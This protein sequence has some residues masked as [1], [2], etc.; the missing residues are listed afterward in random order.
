MEIKGNEIIKKYYKIPMYIWIGYIVSIIVMAVAIY[1]MENIKKS[2]IPEPI[3]FT[4][5]GAIGME[6]NQ[7]AYLEVQGITDEIA[8]YGDA[9]N[10]TDEKND[11]YCIAFNNGYWY[12]VDLNFETIEQLKDIK[13]YTYSTDENATIP[14]SV[15]IYGMT[16]SVSDELKQMLIDYYNQSVEEEYKI[17]IDDFERYFG[18][19][20]LNVRKSPINT[21]IEETF[22]SL[23]VIAI[24]VILVLNILIIINIKKVK[25]YLRNNKYEEELA[26]QLDDNIEEQH[27][28]EKLIITKDFLVDLNGNMGFTAFKF[29]DVKWI[30]MHSVKYYG[31]VTTSTSIKVHLKDCKVNF[32]FA[33]IRGGTTEEFLNIFNKICEKVPDNCLKGYTQENIKLFKEYKK[34][35]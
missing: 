3:D 34:T 10:E 11:R 17:T 1:S 29:S 13:E 9:E 24:F 16:E 25:K 14:E 30:H 21:T 31:I 7:Y 8:I 32:E 12:V 33:K 5:E 20:L 4:T 19:V 18:S 23:A 35:C 15:K 22:I 2:E 26:R 27:Y 28:K 6:E